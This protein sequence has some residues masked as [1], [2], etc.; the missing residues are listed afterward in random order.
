M[1]KNVLFIGQIEYWNTTY[2]RMQGF[3]DLGFDI[4]PINTEGYFNR[5]HSL[6]KRIQYKLINGP[7]VWSMNRDAI[8][9]ARMSQPTIIWVDKGTFIKA[10]TIKKLK[11]VS[12]NSILIHHNTDDIK[13]RTHGFMKNVLPSIP[14]FDIQITSN[15]FNIEDLKAYGAKKVL[16]MELAYNHRLHK[17]VDISEADRKKWQADVSFI[18]H[19]EAATEAY[20]LALREAGIYVRLLGGSW[21]HAEDRQLQSDKNIKMVFGEDYVKAIICSKINICFIS[22][23][24][25]NVIAARSFEIPATKSFLLA[26]RTEEHINYYKEGVEA[27]FFDDAQELIRK[28]K[29][30]LA[31]DTQRL[32][33]AENGHKRCLESGY[34][35]SERIKK[36][37]QEVVS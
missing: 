1:A 33:V 28:I 27:E 9:A 21:D 23:I 7:S 12:P 18:G 25:R 6:I 8:A 36:I 4:V 35:E 29:F 5:Y 24:N 31:N 30:Y 26:Q 32:E 20:I 10:S 2:S 11:E 34:S 22:K 16:H 37:I 3:K 13:C 15:T 17:P 19:W 14:L